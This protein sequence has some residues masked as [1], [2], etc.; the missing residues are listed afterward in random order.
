MGHLA[1]ILVTLGSVVSIGFGA[2]HFF[3]PTLW[4]WYDYMDPAA[5]E[6]VVA[7]R[8]TNV[9]FS[10]SLVLFGLINLAFAW[11]GQA[12]RFALIVVLSATSLLWAV[13]VA[14]Q[15]AYPQGT[16][17]SALQYGML[18]TFIAVALC[19]LAALAL[20]LLS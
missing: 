1:K 7:V 5:T 9:F 20:T 16:L 13:R 10:L 4:K 12:N 15:L 6:L 2:W 3:V 14:M 8:A 11:G 18:A 19:Y 17:N